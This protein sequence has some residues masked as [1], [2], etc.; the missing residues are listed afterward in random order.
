M[1][2]VMKSEKNRNGKGYERME[3]EGRMRKKGKRKE[4][5]KWKTEGVE[6]NGG[7]LHS[8]D[9]CGNGSYA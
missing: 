2:M 4:E 1:K 8:G 3:N 7:K 6:A 9:K 5:Q